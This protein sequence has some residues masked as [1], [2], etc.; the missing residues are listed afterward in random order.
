[1][2]STSAGNY[3]D[4][5][6]SPREDITLFRVNTESDGIQAMRQGIADV[7]VTDEVAFPADA[8]ER[9]HIKLAFRGVESF[10]VAFALRKG[11]TALAEEMNRFPLATGFWELYQSCRK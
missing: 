8:R 10:D 3:F 2:V 5:K 11:D 1:M 9:L 6:Y 4:D 7:H